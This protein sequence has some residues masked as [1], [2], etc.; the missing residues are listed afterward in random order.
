M[1]RPFTGP[2][3]VRDTM[4]KQKSIMIAVAGATVLAVSQGQA[5]INYN[6]DDL[7][8]N[9]RDNAHVLNSGGTAVAISGND[10][11]VD[12]GNINTFLSTA[13]AGASETVVSSGLVTGA[14]AAPSSTAPIGM[15][16]SAG[17]D[18]TS[19]LWLSRTIA[20]PTLSPPAVI[21]AQQVSQGTTVTAIDNIGAGA[22]AGTSDGVGAALVAAA[23][24]GNSYQA[25]GEQN[26]SLAGVQVINFGSSQNVNGTP[27][28]LIEGTQNGTGNIYEALWEVPQLGD[29]S[30]T[31][32]GYFTFQTDGEVDFT[33]VPEPGLYGVLAA[34]GLLVLAMRR[35]LASFVA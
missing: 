30:D 2:K 13:P 6:G 29:G 32:L 1:S 21:S 35:Q 7:L 19:V 25:Q 15:S 5:Q 22:T 33:A 14:F 4:N 26:T 16:A 27:P 34:G 8:L 9:F 17:D 28:K 20:G 18:N 3:T 23:T 24:S 10:L 11:E 31:Y 12:L